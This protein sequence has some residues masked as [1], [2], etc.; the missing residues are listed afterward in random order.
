MLCDN[1]EPKSSSEQY[2]ILDRWI[3]G[4]GSSR[5]WLDASVPEAKL[6]LSSA[7]VA[8]PTAGEF[9]FGKSARSTHCK[10]A[11]SQG[12]DGILVQGVQVGP[13]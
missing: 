11:E 13:F 8:F 9:P 7:L 2:L 6:R 4:Q 5:T 3:I 1:L 12:R 10:I